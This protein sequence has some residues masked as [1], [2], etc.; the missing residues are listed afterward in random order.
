MPPRAGA[1]P[2]ADR[3]ALPSGPHPQGYSPVLD[4]LFA[5][6]V[7]TGARSTIYT[8]QF[9]CSILSQGLGPAIAALLFWLHGNTWDI[10]V[11]P[12]QQ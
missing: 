10:E 12:L 4:A 7:P 8:T 3:P 9:I 1:A 5:D 6:S 11:G 2:L